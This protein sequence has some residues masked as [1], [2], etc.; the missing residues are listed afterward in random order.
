MEEPK[1][2]GDDDDDDDKSYSTLLCNWLTA[3]P[4]VSGHSGDGQSHTTRTALW[5]GQIY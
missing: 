1:K 2:H 4:D 3:G 5:E